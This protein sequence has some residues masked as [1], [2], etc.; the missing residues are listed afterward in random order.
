VTERGREG[1]RGK[2]GKGGKGGQGGGEGTGDGREGGDREVQLQQAEVAEQEGICD[3]WQLRL[4]AISKCGEGPEELAEAKGKEAIALADLQ[5]AT[6][7][8]EAL[9]AKQQ[10]VHSKNF[11]GALEAFN[12]IKGYLGDKVVLKEGE[13][14]GKSDDFTAKEAYKVI[15]KLGEFLRHFQDLKADSAADSQMDSQMIVES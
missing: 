1:K 6:E 4:R 9:T 7:I 5:K 14:W 10:A 2:G 15:W 3:T 13:G 8:L 11:M 12:K